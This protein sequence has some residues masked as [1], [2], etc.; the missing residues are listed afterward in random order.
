MRDSPALGSSSW[1]S[2]V[3]MVFLLQPG[4]IFQNKSRLKIDTSS[5]VMIELRDHFLLVQ[6]WF[7]EAYSCL[8]VFFYFL[9]FYFQW[10]LFILSFSKST[11]SRLVWLLYSSIDT[12]FVLV[13]LNSISI[14]ILMSM[15]TL[16]IFPLCYSME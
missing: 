6:I 8:Y 9:K 4:Y 2:K 16:F 11:G 5:K 13:F 14:L 10:I 12:I 1:V 15:L 3:I 7:P